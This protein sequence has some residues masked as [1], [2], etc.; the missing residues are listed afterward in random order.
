MGL[1]SVIVPTHDQ[2]ENIRPLHQV[3]SRAWTLT[4]SA[5]GGQE[6]HLVPLFEGD[7]AVALLAVNGG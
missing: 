7:G 2:W 4:A 3:L 1:P 6:G 5:E